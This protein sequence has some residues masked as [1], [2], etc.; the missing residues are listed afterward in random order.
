MKGSVEPGA[1][2]CIQ[3]FPYYL[4]VLILVASF[5][6]KAKIKFVIYGMVES[7]ESDIVL[8]QAVFFIYPQQIRVGSVVA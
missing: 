4:H 8:I 3:S 6:S 5:T 1:T 7:A 2:F